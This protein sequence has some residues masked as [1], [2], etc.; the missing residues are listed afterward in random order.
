M[1][2]IKEEP[3][4]GSKSSIKQTILTVVQYYRSQGLDRFMNMFNFLS[5]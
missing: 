5:N 1:I 4:S 2:V 3:G